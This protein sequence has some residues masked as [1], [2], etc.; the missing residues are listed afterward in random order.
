MRV[1]R[2]M[3]DNRSVPRL[4]LVLR[5]SLGGVRGRGLG[6]IRRCWRLL[7]LLCALSRWL[8]GSNSE[9]LLQFVFAESCYEDVVVHDRGWVIEGA[10][11]A[12]DLFADLFFFVFFAEVNVD[13]FVCYF[14]VLEEL[15]CHF[16]PY[17]GAESVHD[18]LVVVLFSFD[19][20]E[21]HFLTR[22][23]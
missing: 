16:A 12:C 13:V 3:R 11:F 18:D 20:V 6:G 2:G 22:Y 1:C 8:W 19:F 5:G 17:A 14:V 7:L 21:M 9:S 15:F 4:F 23:P 10:A